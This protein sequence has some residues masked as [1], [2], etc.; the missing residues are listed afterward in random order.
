MSFQKDL[1]TKSTNSKQ[2]IAEKSDHMI[3]RHEPSIIIEAIK[4]Q[5]DL[6]RTKQ[7]NL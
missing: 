4:E 6:V 7:N 5:V 2:V 3:T 1:L